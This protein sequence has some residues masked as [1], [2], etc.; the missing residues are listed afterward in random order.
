MVAPGSVAVGVV[1]TLLLEGV[2]VVEEVEGSVLVGPDP[3]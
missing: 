3:G 1:V 2:A